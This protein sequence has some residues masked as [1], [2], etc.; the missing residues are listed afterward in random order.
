MEKGI[1]IPRF[2]DEPITVVYSSEPLLQKS[3]RCPD[4][5]IWNDERFQIINLLLEWADFTR[6]G[7]MAR[8][9]SEPHSASAAVKGSWGVGKFFFR[10][11]TSCGRVFDIYYDRAPKG[12]ANR[13]GLWFI[14]KELQNEQNNSSANIDLE[15]DGEG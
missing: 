4:E 11:E 5:F 3:P 12:S 13:K 9:M 15:K 10:V 2:I 6:R 8:N 14:Y 1:T 7:K